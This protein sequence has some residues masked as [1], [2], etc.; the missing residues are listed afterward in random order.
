MIEVY[1]QTISII[2]FLEANNLEFKRTKKPLRGSCIPPN[3]SVVRYEG[4]L[5]S[6]KTFKSIYRKKLD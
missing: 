6:E 3:V 4:V 5:Y 2:L 1:P